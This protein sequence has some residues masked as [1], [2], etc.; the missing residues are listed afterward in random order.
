LIKNG[1]QRSYI[2][3]RKQNANNEDDIEINAYRTDE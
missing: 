1:S 3:P 2:Y